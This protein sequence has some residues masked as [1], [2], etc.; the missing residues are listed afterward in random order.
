LLEMMLSMGVI[1]LVLGMTAML[2]TDYSQSLKQGSSRE[3]LLDAL[4][5]GAERIRSELVSAVSITSPPASGV[6]TTLN[7]DRVDPASVNRLG[8]PTAPPFEWEPYDDS[9]MLV[10]SYSL[11]NGAL[12]RAAT[13]PVSSSQEQLCENLQGLTAEF[14]D[15]RTVQVVLSVDVRG[16]F[17]EIRTEV[18][19]WIEP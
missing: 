14:V 16:S 11:S 13:G 1:F 12:I 6:S 2:V 15:G 4:E 18:P 8:D 19:L 3:T 10:V 5:F 7:F 17:N 9:Y